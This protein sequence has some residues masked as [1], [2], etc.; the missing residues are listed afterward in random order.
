MG[1][2]G[3]WEASKTSLPALALWTYVMSELMN[4]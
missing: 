4:E 3:S 1:M 2:L